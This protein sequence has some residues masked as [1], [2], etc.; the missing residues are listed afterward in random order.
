MTLVFDIIMI[1]SR[2]LCFY[3]FV[4]SKYTLWQFQNG[5]VDQNRS[6]IDQDTWN[7]VKIPKLKNKCFCSKMMFCGTKTVIIRF[8]NFYKIPCILVNFWPILVHFTILEL[9]K[10]VLWVYKLRSRWNILMYSCN[11]FM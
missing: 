1:L 9:S 3:L 11:H 4:Y 6:K 2:G 8:L 5:K 7:L 10:C